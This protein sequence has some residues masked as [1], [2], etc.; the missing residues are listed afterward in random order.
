MLGAYIYPVPKE[1][2]LAIYVLLF[3][4]IFSNLGLKLLAK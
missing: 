3:K 4:E 1:L 2:K